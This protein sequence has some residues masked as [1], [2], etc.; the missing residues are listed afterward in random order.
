[1]PYRLKQ[2]CPDCREGWLVLLTCPACRKIIA[3]CDEDGGVFANG[4]AFDKPTAGTGDIA[5][6]TITECP[7]CRNVFEFHFSKRA[8]ILGAGVPAKGF[9]RFPMWPGAH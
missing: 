6:S 5:V 7:A 2:R 1:M 4:P 8:E 9:M 3:A